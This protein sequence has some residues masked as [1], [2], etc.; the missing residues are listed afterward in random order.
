MQVFFGTVIRN[1]PVRRSGELVRLDWQTKTVE[2][3][4]PMF[5]TDPD[6]DHDPNPRGN[7]RGCKGITFSGDY[8][9]AATY[10]TLKMFDLQLRHQADVSHG[11]LV[12]VHELFS[13]ET[14]KIWISSTAVD[15]ALRCDLDSGTVTDSFWPRE[16][17]QFK[18]A[19][20]VMPLE[21]DKADD[22]RAKF[23]DTKHNKDPSHLHLNAV[24]GWR[25]EIFALFNRFGAIV[26]LSAGTVVYQEPALKGG[27][28]LLIMED[29]TAVVNDTL[30]R[31]VRFYDVHSRALVRVIELT[32]FPWV[33]S[34]ARP[35]RVTNLVK[36]GLKKFRIVR[37]SIARPLFVRG[38]DLMG[39]LLFVGLS[40]AAIL[41]IDW[42]KETLVD[43][44]RY[45]RNVLVCVHGLRVRA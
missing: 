36:A 24:A 15:S 2:A 34:L 19:F 39:D 42:R 22:N 1:A 26:N 28:N 23:L 12:G 31:T 9:V 16:M 18:D 33:R 38:L 40:P 45:S 32:R 29:G 5:P 3:V 10:H 11:L 14:G 43:A 35:A 7:S 25:G 37:S 17:P 21:L 4:A 6:L 8:V 44:Y 41:A 13:N 30:G 27:H 20:G